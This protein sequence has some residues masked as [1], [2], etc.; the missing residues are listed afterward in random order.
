MNWGETVHKRAFVASDNKRGRYTIDIYHTIIHRAY[1]PIENLS[2]LTTR[3]TTRE[4]QGQRRIRNL[5]VW[6][7]APFR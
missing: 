1:G 3:R 5:R 2:S 6:A 7:N 4:S